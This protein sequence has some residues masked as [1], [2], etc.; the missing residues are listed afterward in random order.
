MAA[1]LVAPSVGGVRP[2]LLPG[3]PSAYIYSS[4]EIRNTGQEVECNGGRVLPQSSASTGC[5]K[6]IV[7]AAAAEPT[8]VV[9]SIANSPACPRAP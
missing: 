5:S 8:E 3:V 4:L 1:L 6:D 9:T 2:V 7:Y